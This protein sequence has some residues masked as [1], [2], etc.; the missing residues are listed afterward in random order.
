MFPKHHP[1]LTLVQV[2]LVNTMVRLFS[3][4]HLS[5]RSGILDIRVY[6][7]PGCVTL[8]TVVVG[9]MDASGMNAVTCTGEHTHTGIQ[10]RRG[11]F[12]SPAEQDDKVGKKIEEE[13]SNKNELPLDLDEKSKTTQE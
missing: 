11:A 4:A 8:S 12:I 7:H 3:K 13:K 9:G 2:L 1:L 6:I 10:P 5:I